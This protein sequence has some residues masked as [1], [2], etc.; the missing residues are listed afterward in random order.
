MWNIWHAC[1]CSMNIISSLSSKNDL[2]KETFCI[3]C[4]LN[5]IKK[6]HF[7]SF[8]HCIK[9]VHIQSY[10]GPHFPAFRI[11]ME[12]YEVYKSIQNIQS[13]WKIRSIQNISLYFMY[14][15]RMWENVDQNNSEFG[16]YLCSVYY[17][18]ESDF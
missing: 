13:I 10:S 17:S 5:I 12:R 14:S 18:R 1:V 16:H 2:K 6:E 3:I 8:H 15:V 11:N 9:S 7:I 4:F